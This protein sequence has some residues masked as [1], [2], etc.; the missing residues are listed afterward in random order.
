MGTGASCLIHCD[1]LAGL[2]HLWGVWWQV[3]PVL[4]QPMVGS[5]PERSILRLSVKSA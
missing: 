5:E 2:G 1:L 4:N 3:A